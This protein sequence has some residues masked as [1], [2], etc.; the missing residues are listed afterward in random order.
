MP[1]QDRYLH[2][3]I[4]EDLKE[5]M[6]FLAGPRQVGKTT[7]AKLVGKQD[8]DAAK[9]LLWDDV[10]DQRAILRGGFEADADLVI[11]DEIHKYRQWKN[12]V[13][14]LYDKHKNDY[15]LLITGSA[16]LDLYRK[17]GDSLQGRYF[18][19]RL[20]PFSLAELQKIKPAI[21]VFKPLRFPLGN[22]SSKK[23]LQK[24]LTF[25][26]FPE[27]FFK[28]SERALRRWQLTRIDRLVKEDIREIELVR[29]ISA[30]QILS[31]LLE[32]LAGTRLSLNALREDLQVNH[33]TIALWVE[34]L[35]RFYYHF[36]IAPFSSKLFSS[37]KKEPKLYL[38]DWS[39][40]EDP[41]RKF[42]NLVA[43]HVLKYCHYLQD[44]EGYRAELWYL[45][46]TFGR[47]VDFLVTVNRK[48]WFAVETKVSDTEPS[49]HLRYFQ[50]KL[51]I[52]FLYQVV[53]NTEQD[54]LQDKI[55][56]MGAD[57]FLSG[58]V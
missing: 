43:S 48:P 45:R 10:M 37:L 36:R 15:S 13:K 18:L 58:L 17:G 53:L 38:W 12:H 23:V 30:L 25:G 46:D 14:G 19:F 8:F 6:V 7:L 20:H 40:I 21:A 52:P 49:P 47:E 54:I 41:G 57:K 33:K 11:L 31:G 3:L 1:S 44:A 56:I 55:R 24:L 34:I 28:G 4:S 9:Y 50:E 32:K 26:G 39:P 2:R 29:D 35:E 27:P 16:R 5:K 22:A 42:E 51:S